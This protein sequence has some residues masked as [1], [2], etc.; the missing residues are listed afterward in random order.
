[1]FSAGWGKR[2]VAHDGMAVG[3]WSRHENPPEFESRAQKS[4]RFQ[5]DDRLAWAA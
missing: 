3:H 4:L 2:P 5:Q 1:M